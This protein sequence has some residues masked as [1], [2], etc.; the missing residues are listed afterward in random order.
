MFYFRK[1]KYRYLKKDHFLKALGPLN[2]SK[3]QPFFLFMFLFINF[4]WI[5]NSV[6]KK[7]TSTLDDESEDEFFE[8]DDYNRTQHRT[9][10]LVTRNESTTDN[11]SGGDYDKQNG[12]RKDQF[13]FT[14]DKDHLSADGKV[15]TSTSKQPRS[16]THNLSCSLLIV[17][18]IMFI[19]FFFLIL[20]QH[21]KCTLIDHSIIKSKT[22]PNCN[23][24]KTVSKLTDNLNFGFKTVFSQISSS[25]GLLDFLPSWFFNQSGEEIW[26]FSS[27]FFSCF[28]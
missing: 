21:W 13:V 15:N 1:I 26:W 23:Y 10:E 22:A 18:S 3:V 14:S 19:F 9:N 16:L 12:M 8:H 4:D 2:F 20:I 25:S 6:P 24:Q 5:F 7:Q 27:I 17:V 28:F 11:L